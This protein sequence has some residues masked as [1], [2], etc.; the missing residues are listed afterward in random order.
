[1]NYKKIS[2]KNI[3][4]KFST[5]TRDIIIKIFV[6]PVACLLASILLKTRT[7]ANQVT[8]IN[9]IISILFL[10][11]SIMINHNFIYIGIAIFFILDFTD[12]KIARIKRLND[13]FGKKLD[14]TVDRIIFCIYSI[15]FF[16]YQLEINN[17]LNNYLLLYVLIYVSKDFYERISTKN[18]LK[19]FEKNYRY[20]N[21]YTY[22][23]NYKNLIIERV[24]TP[25][26]IL[27]ICYTTKYY[28]LAYIMG[29]LSIYMK[30]YTSFIKKK[31]SR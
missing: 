25:I 13:N 3:L 31:I 10:I 17:K 8:I 7:T 29:T 22:Y 11:I 20:H 16:F 1:M 15:F 4:L 18:N 14:F 6:E 27:L 30:N 23:F 9:L 24:S 12:G 19:K 21:I 5:P 26:L 2:I 28:E